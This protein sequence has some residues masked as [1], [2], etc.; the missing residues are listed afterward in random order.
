MNP[1]QL[2]FKKCIEKLFPDIILALMKQGQVNGALHT[3]WPFGYGQKCGFWC[4]A[5]Q[6]SESFLCMTQRTPGKTKEVLD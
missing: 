6:I 1:L 5:E 2:L 4:K 3:N